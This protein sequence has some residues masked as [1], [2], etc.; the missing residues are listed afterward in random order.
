M[1]ALG[2]LLLRRQQTREAAGLS[3]ATTI[4]FGLS[5]VRVERVEAIAGGGRTVHVA[6]A[7]SS[8]AGCRSC[9]GVSTS[10]KEQMTTL[11]KD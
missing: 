4:L 3:N 10:V 2:V 6:A 1:V 7:D 9:G 5:G 11:P 8:A